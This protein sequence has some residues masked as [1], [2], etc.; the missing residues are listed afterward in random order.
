MERKLKNID[1]WNKKHMVYIYSLMITTVE[2]K[3][4]KI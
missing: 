4:K 2:E 3:K 1:E